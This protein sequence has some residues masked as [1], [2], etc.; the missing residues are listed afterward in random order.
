M[1]GA[2]GNMIDVCIDQAVDLVL[3]DPVILL[4]L[5]YRQGH[6]CNRG[7]QHTAGSHQGNLNVQFHRSPA[8]RWSFFFLKGLAEEVVVL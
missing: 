5:P 7:H 3:S 4:A 6:Q 8:V 1:I 2:S